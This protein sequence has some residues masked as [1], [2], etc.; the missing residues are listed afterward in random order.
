MSPMRQ[1]VIRPL[2]SLSYSKIS[3]QVGLQSRNR[4]ETT[5]PCKW[6]FQVPRLH[7]CTLLILPGGRKMGP[8][9]ITSGWLNQ[10]KTAPLIRGS[11]H[12]CRQNNEIF[13]SGHILD[14]LQWAPGEDNE[15]GKEGPGDCGSTD[16]NLLWWNNIKILT[17][18][19]F[20][21]GDILNSF[22]FPCNLWFIYQSSTPTIRSPLFLFY[23]IFS[24]SRFPDK[25]QA[26][27]RTF[28]LSSTL[29]RYLGV[30]NIRQDWACVPSGKRCLNWDLSIDST[31]VVP[32]WTTRSHL[33]LGKTKAGVLPLTVSCLHFT[34]KPK[35]IKRVS[36]LGCA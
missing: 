2:F 15:G 28:P 25:S 4:R 26:S 35:T 22:A 1:V 19:R 7:C 36:C 29:V 5:K 18:N 27:P 10:G 23:S 33:G 6:C 30:S 32:T 9:E 24:P 17:S 11:G 31:V 16:V 8:Q 34:R 14:D 21:V 13:I 12:L 3:H 20:K